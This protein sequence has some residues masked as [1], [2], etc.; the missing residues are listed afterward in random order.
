LHEGVYAGLS[1][2]TYETP[3]EVRM[4]AGMGADLVGMSTV[5][6][7]IVARYLGARVLGVSVV[8]NPAAGISDE[9]LV[10]EEVAEAGRRAAARLERLLRGVCRRLPELLERA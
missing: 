8:T 3:A 5:H 1:G 6:E 9:P 10:H 2:P 4:L 7:A